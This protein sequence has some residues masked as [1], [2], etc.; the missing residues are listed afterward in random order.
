MAFGGIRYQTA[1]WRKVTLQISRS[2]FRAGICGDSVALSKRQVL[3]RFICVLGSVAVTHLFQSA[4]VAQEGAR[5]SCLDLDSLANTDRDS[6]AALQG[7]ID[8]A[9]AG[10]TLELKGG[11]CLHHRATGEDLKEYFPY[12]CWASRLRV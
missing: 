8:R 7:C 1:A 11:G 4:A 12:N 6:S 3:F 5:V 9:Q 10:A 2:S